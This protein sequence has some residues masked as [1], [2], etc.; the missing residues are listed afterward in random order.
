MFT[1]AQKE[2]IKTELKDFMHYFGYVDHP[3]ITDNLTAFF[4]YDDQTEAEIQSINGFKR[5]NEDILKKLG[6]AMDPKFF[7]IGGRKLMN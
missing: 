7:M 1:D 4:K 5:Q 6:Q 2:Y 3:S